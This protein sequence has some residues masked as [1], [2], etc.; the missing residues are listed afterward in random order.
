[1]KI[2][3]YYLVV[4]VVLGVQTAPDP[5]HDDGSPHSSPLVDGDS[6]P[7]ELLGLPAHHEV[8]GPGEAEHHV[9]PPGL[10][11]LQAQ[12]GLGQVLLGDP[13]ESLCLLYKTGAL[14][15]PEAKPVVLRSV[16]V[17]GRLLGVVHDVLEEVADHLLSAGRHHHLGVVELIEKQ[18]ILGLDLIELGLPVT[19][20]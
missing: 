16:G 11:L 20:L 9:L 13:L 5:V 7:D 18:E 17:Q 14:L 19:G 4:L 10:H 8:A 1:M 3:K 12:L 6:S 15:E 2:L